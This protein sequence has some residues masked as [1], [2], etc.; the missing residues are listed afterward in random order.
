MKLTRLLHE[1]I[2]KQLAKNSYP[3]VKIT[4]SHSATAEN[5]YRQALIDLR[6]T[7][8]ILLPNDEPTEV[9]VPITDEDLHEHP[10]QSYRPAHVEWD[11]KNAGYDGGEFPV[12]LMNIHNLPNSGK[13][14]RLL[15]PD[16]IRSKF[17][18]TAHFVEPSEESFWKSLGYT[19]VPFI[20]FFAGFGLG[21][22]TMVLPLA[23]R[24][25]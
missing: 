25:V 23:G 10:L 11:T 9:M 12:S 19:A 21:I 14:E 7:G 18:N 8:P 5:G 20:I 16:E 4:A 13:K 24:L 1:W 3:H 6:D 22:M 15:T 2:E 17:K